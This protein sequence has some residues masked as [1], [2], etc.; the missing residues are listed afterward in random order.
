MQLNLTANQSE[1][2]RTM[3]AV[4]GIA[5]I[6]AAAVGFIGWWGYIGFI[7]LVTGLW[8]FCPLYRLFG[9]SSRRPN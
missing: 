9:L 6:I 7:P 8:G 2:E 3:R 1:F 4:V 5:L